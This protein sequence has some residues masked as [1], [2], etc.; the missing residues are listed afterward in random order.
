MKKINITTEAINYIAEQEIIRKHE[1]KAKAEIRKNR[2]KELMAQ[3]IEKEIA[4]VMA[5]V[6]V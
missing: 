1:K 3:G 6:G 4:E 2:I 5:A